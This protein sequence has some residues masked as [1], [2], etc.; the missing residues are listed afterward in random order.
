MNTPYPK[1][2]LYLTQG[3]GRCPKGG[4]PACKVLH[5]HNELILLRDIL[6]DSDLKEVLKWSQ[7]CYTFNGNNVAILAAFNNYVVISFFKGALLNDNNGV[8]IKAGE[9]TQSA[10]MLRFTSTQQIMEAKV[11]IHDFI[12]QAIALEKQGKKVTLDKAL[13]SIPEEL[14]QKLSEDNLF[15][16]A[17][18]SLTPGRQKGYILYFSEAKKTE[19]R[20]SRIEKYIPKILA[21]KGMND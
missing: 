14:L 18:E 4:T 6:L 10:R 20:K 1:V 7:P 19:T 3:C 8:L 11:L 5:W 2:D 13:P 15:K 9:N 17:F 21:G 12:K 16:T